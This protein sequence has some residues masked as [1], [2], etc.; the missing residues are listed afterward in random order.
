MKHGLLVFCWFGPIGLAY[1]QSAN[2]IKATIAETANGRT[3]AVLE[4]NSTVV[5]TAVAFSSNSAEGLKTLGG[6]VQQAV[7]GKI[8]A[9]IPV[10]CDSAVQQWKEVEPGQ[11]AR[12]GFGSV[13]RSAELDLKAAILADGRTFGDAALIEAML[14]RRR[15]TLE[16]LEIILRHLP[17]TVTGITSPTQLLQLFRSCRQEQLK[18]LQIND[19][20]QIAVINANLIMERK[21]KIMTGP[22]DSA[23]TAITTMLRD[24]QTSLSRSLPNLIAVR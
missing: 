12:I 14:A 1:A 15:A 24:W 7:P 6:D 19:P 8:R 22:P 18:G 3:E 13:Y 11:R 9:V 17:T 5:L 10:Y 21:L 16:G 23:V 20:V 4:N 2:P